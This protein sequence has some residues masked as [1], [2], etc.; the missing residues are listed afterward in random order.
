MNVHGYCTRCKRIRRVNVTAP[1]TGTPT[2]ICA[3]CQQKEVDT[4]A[5]VGELTIYVPVGPIT[6]II[7]PGSA[8]VGRPGN[9]SRTTVYYESGRH[10]EEHDR[11]F[12]SLL[13]HAASRLVTKYPTIALASLQDDELIPVGTYDYASK[14][15]TITD[16][17]TF[18]AWRAH[19]RT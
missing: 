6:S 12:D 8:V 9:G 10:Y 18:N 16:P 17:T 11:T 2:G 3:E 7:D 19:A 13:L 5:R 1:F 4:R 15:H 14:T